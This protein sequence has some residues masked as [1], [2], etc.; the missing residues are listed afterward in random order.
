MFFWILYSLR[1][2]QENI[3]FYKMLSTYSAISPYF[4][5]VIVVVDKKMRSFRNN[6]FDYLSF[7]NCITVINVYIDNMVIENKTIKL[8][9]NS[10]I[11]ERDMLLNKL[12]KDADMS[13]AQFA[14]EI[15][16]DASTINRWIKNSRSIAWE[17]AEKIAKVLNCHPVDIYKPKNQITL[18]S[19]VQWDGY[20]MDFAKDEQSIIS[21]PYEYYHKNITS[22]QMQ[23]PGYHADGEIF[24]FDIPTT[25]KFSK[26][27][28]GKICYMTATQSYKKKNQKKFKEMNQECKP[29]VALLKAKGNGRLSIVNSYT[30]TPINSL[31]EDIGPEDIEIATPIKVRYDPDL[32][33]ITIK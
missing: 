30:D 28:I 32:L 8:I 26:F 7:C 19:Y 21:I 11:E 5:Q 31:C 4:T 23:A 27:A 2:R 1:F 20:V 14:K 16:K 6:F 9:K 29:L 10:H 18:K 22:I 12:L 25:K 33:N 13:Q 17:N 24:L 15:G 3:A